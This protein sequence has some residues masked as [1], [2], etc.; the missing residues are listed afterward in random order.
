MTHKETLQSVTRDPTGFIDEE[1]LRQVA[2][3]LRD[4]MEIV[5]EPRLAAVLHRFVYTRAEYGD[6]LPSGLNR[7]PKSTLEQ[8][9]KCA[10]QSL[11]LA[12]LCAQV[13]L[14][15]RITSVERQDGNAYHAFVE[16]GFA[17]TLSEVITELGAFYHEHGILTP[18]SYRYFEGELAYFIAD[19]V[20]SRYIGEDDS[21][22]EMGYIDSTGTLIINRRFKL[23]NQTT[24]LQST[25]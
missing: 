17:S 9:G 1:Y 15:T 24:E 19:P 7:P 25:G 21:L 2:T 18:G 16:I 10:D 4:A 13:G 22:R 8:N 6:E 14:R 5:S 20:V 11:L 3:Q 12:A 23:P